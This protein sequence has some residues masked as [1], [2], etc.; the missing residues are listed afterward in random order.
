MKSKSVAYLLW[1]FLGW[2][3]V[4]RFYLGKVG[5]GILYL[6][7]FG[8]FGVGLL[9]DLFTL[10][11]KVD[12]YNALLMGRMNSGNANFASSNTN[13]IVVN[14]PEQRYAAPSPMPAIANDKKPE[15]SVADQ[16]LQLGELKDKL[17]ITE[18]E[19]LVQKARLLSG[20]AVRMENE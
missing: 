2:L 4:H 12:V 13:N 14:I 5:T 15:L 18:E 6:F 11:G 3:G 1:F 19:F 8:L 9:I 7:T 10:G 20:G 17:V 16:L